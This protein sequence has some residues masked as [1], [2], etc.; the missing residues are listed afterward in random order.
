MLLDF[1]QNLSQTDRAVRVII[2]F[3]LLSLSLSHTLSGG[4]AVLS[5]VLA[6]SQFIEGALGY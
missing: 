3:I 4:W 5:V 2:G 6:I 1:K